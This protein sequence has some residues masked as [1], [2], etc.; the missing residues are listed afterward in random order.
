MEPRNPSIRPARPRRTA[1][2][3]RLVLRSAQAVLALLGAVSW[4]VT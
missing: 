3:L 1:R 4:V 2:A